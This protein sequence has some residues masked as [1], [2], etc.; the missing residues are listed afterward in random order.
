[1]NRLLFIEWVTEFDRA[2]VR[3]KRKV[4]LFM[5]NATSHPSDVK[6]KN[7]TLKF[8]PVNTTSQLQPLDQGI[9]R[10]IK[11]HYRKR[12]VRAVL[13]RIDEGH[14]AT[15]VARCVSVLDACQWVASAWKET[16]TS[17]MA[18]CFTMSVGGIR[19]EGNQHIDCGKVLYHVSG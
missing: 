2:M 14:N 11:A 19:L 12:F 18:K 3:Q 7:V 1:M 13:T 16:N 8:F 4:L 6:L 5:D 15:D 17:T 9:I 10:A